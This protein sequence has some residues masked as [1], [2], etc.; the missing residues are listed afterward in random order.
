MESNSEQ[1]EKEI[2][3]GDFFS[4]KG[5]S[6]G[7]Q[8]F[9]AIWIIAGFFLIFAYLHYSKPVITSQYVG[10]KANMTVYNAL[11]KNP[12]CHLDKIMMK[13][14]DFVIFKSLDEARDKGYLLDG[15]CY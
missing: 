15:E 8:I 14:Y 11:S 5:M 3:L 9:M 12:R 10:D 7:K 4:S 1:Q 6:K 13:D 2:N